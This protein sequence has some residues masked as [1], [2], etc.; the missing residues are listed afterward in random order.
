MRQSGLSFLFFFLFICYPDIEIFGQV[1]NNDTSGGSSFQDKPGASDEGS[2]QF[3]PGHITV[4]Q[5]QSISDK[6]SLTNLSQEVYSTCSFTFNDLL[7]F[8]YEDNNEIIIC[9]SSRYIIWH[10]TLGDNQ[11][12]SLSVGEGVYCVYSSKP[13]SLLIG[14]PISEDVMG[15]YAMNDAGKGVGNEVLTYMPRDAYGQEKFIVFGYYD[16]SLVEITDIEINEVIWIGVIDRDEHYVSSLINNRFIKV[17]SNYPVS[18]L[19]YADQGYLVPDQSGNWTGTE[20]YGYAGFVGHWPNELNIVSYSDSANVFVI[21]TETDSTIWEGSIKLG[22]IINLI[23][24]DSNTLE[25]YFKVISDDI[26][27]VSVSPYQ[28]ST[29][30]YYYLAGCSDLNGTGIGNL[31]YVPALDY[32]KLVFN[33]FE[34]NNNISITNL[35]TGSVVYNNVLKGGAYLTMSTTNNMYK[36]E[37]SGKL[38]G[39]VSCMSSNGAAFVPVYYGLDLPDLTITPSSIFFKPET[40]NPGDQI[41]INA[42]IKNIG[43]KDIYDIQVGFYDGNP[44]FGGKQIGSYKTIDSI[45]HGMIP[46][47]V[48]TTMIVPENP[49]YTQI[50]V[51]VDPLNKIA[52]SSES[53]NLTSENLVP[54]EEL[55]P[56]LAIHI[57]APEK[58]TLDESGNYQ[59]N[60]F[61][62]EVFAMNDSKVTAEKVA[63]MINLPPGLVLADGENNVHFLGTIPAG[64]SLMTSWQIKATGEDFG[65]LFYSF[66]L[67]GNDLEDKYANRKIIIPESAPETEVTVMWNNQKV[68]G[69]TI[70][71]DPDL[72]GFKEV[73]TITDINKPMIV[74]NLNAGSRIRAEK[75]MFCQNAVKDVHEAVDGLMFEVWFDSDIM[76]VDGNY[77]SIAITELK[78]KITLELNHCIYKYNLVFTTNEEEWSIDN[79]YYEKLEKGIREASRFL[80]NSTDGQ[81]ML[82][83]VAIY[84]TRRIFGFADVVLHMSLDREYCDEVGGIDHKFEGIFF[85]PSKLHMGMRQSYRN[86]EPD[87]LDWYSTFVHEFG[88]YAFGLY[89]EYLNGYGVPWKYWFFYNWDPGG[90]EHPSNYGVMEYQVSTREFSSDNDYLESY[91]ANCAAYKVTQ[92]F[93]EYRM[94]CFNYIKTK[95]ENYFSGAGIKLPP[96]GFYPSGYLYDR[97]GPNANRAYDEPVILDMRSDKKSESVPQQSTIKVLTGNRSITNAR[98]YNHSNDQ[99]KYLGVTDNNGELTWFNPMKG[100]EIIAYFNYNHRTFRQKLEVYELQP[101][102]IIRPDFTNI[103]NTN[104]SN[105]TDTSSVGICISGEIKSDKDFLININLISDAPLDTIPVIVAYLGSVIDTFRLS[106]IDAGMMNFTASYPFKETM[107]TYEGF[108]GSGFLDISYRS[109]HK[110]EYATTYLKIFPVSNERSSMHYNRA[111]NLNIVKGNIPEPEIGIS[112]TTYGIPAGTKAKSLYPVTDVFSFSIENISS[113]AEGAGLN[114]QF[115][116]DTSSYIDYSSLRM[117]KMNPVSAEWE[118]LDE[119]YVN[120]EDHIAAYLTPS[121]GT[122]CLFANNLTSD[123]TAPERIRDLSAKTG[124]GQG[125]IEL[126]WT[127]PIDLTDDSIA[128]YIIRYNDVP[129]TLLNWEESLDVYGPSVTLNSGEPATFIAKMPL[130]NQLYY[131][132]MKSVDF[133]GNISEISN[134]ASAISAIRKYTFS[135]I[136]P[137]F[138]DTIDSFTPLFKW[139]SFPE[140]NVKYN[141]L[142]DLDPLF[143]DP[144]MITGLESPEYQLTEALKSNEVYFWKVIAILDEA[145]TILCNQSYFRF[146]S[147]PEVA[148][149]DISDQVMNTAYFYPNPFNPGIEAGSLRFILDEPGMVSISVYNI[150]GQKVSDINHNYSNA[151]N[152]EIVHWPGKEPNKNKLPDGI[153]IYKLVQNNIL[154]FTGKVMIIN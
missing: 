41:T 8:S 62:V 14:D 19:S 11:F 47:P 30:N 93:Y 23:L 137:A 144:L 52:E 9:N 58:L 131:F 56:P 3:R 116:I 26:V 53:N 118:I 117:Y 96:Y 100:G 4:D 54:N 113:F 129:I 36:I 75:K 10:G 44:L 17:R 111:F 126:T 120:I 81:V 33:S 39:N 108:D 147:Q 68:D 24:T 29:S 66:K 143:S 38:A 59:P 128:Y 119:S 112:F 12:Q 135:M 121:T 25:V 89:D 48:K 79:V 124:N 153:Y 127:A 92:Q 42:S 98:I 115:K 114:V 85:A 21:N 7:I 149:H 91:P 5:T 110:W 55:K 139:E 35:S 34:E 132:A 80:Y 31:F 1:I 102:Y 106:Y 51:Y 37:S 65:E 136:S 151:G 71:V 109:G 83:K 148:V 20:F 61:K 130:S 72:L 77:G 16:Q 67:T 76:L 87:W 2:V 133:A 105:D 150:N 154:K 46:V 32:G 152:E 146:I 40:F 57:K 101:E 140:E 50:F 97:P 141:L 70:Y 13:F 73:G 63:C 86:L 60:P 107:F 45:H 103:E 123:R 94:P 69:V 43:N 84:D 15:Y 134:Y 122:F 90:P 28:N 18:V 145:D 88:H 6:K 125:M 95:L 22:E 138:N 142:L 99:L 64:F 82:N 49:E 27:T 104:K 74:K 78:D